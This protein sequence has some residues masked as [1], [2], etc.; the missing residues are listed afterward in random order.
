MTDKDVLRPQLWTPRSTEESMAIYAD[1]AKTYDADITA[2]GYHTPS[3]IAAALKGQVPPGAP[4]LDYGCGTGISGKALQEA[5]FSLIDGT[6][7][8]PEMLDIATG[9]GLYRSTWQ[10]S[11]DVLEIEPGAYDAIV[12]AGVVSLGAAP[13][14]M[15]RVL[16]HKLTAG[17]FL[18]FSYNDPTLKDDG[19][20]TALSDEVD[21]GH[22]EVVFREHGPHLDDVDMGS[23][24]I[25]LRRL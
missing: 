17:Q 9:S 4:I 20:T 21:S 7:I 15:L 16:T 22:V 14:S 19:Y 2:R 8:T 10:A 5:G 1:W 12:A 23:D 3:R 25:L 6:D 11:P 13:P 24:I 18:A